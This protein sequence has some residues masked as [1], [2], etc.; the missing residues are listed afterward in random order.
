MS[1]TQAAWIIGIIVLVIGVP[2]VCAC[3]RSSQKSKLLRKVN[4]QNARLRAT[5]SYSSIMEV[6]RGK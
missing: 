3:I 6:L 5:M 1:I 4:K 2:A